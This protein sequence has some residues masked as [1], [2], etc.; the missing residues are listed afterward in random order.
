M[1]DFVDDKMDVETDLYFVQN[2]PFISKQNCTI[3]KPC[4]GPVYDEVPNQTENISLD[5]C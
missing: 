4:S 2:Q 5:S 1:N 3:C